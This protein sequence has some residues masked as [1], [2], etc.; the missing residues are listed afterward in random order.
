MIRVAH[1][2]KRA[3]SKETGGYETSSTPIGR[4]HL[5]SQWSNLPTPIL[6]EIFILAFD[7]NVCSFRG[8][9]LLMRKLGLER[10]SLARIAKAGRGGKLARRLFIHQSL[11]RSRSAEDIASNM[12]I[13][14]LV[15]HHISN[16]NIDWLSCE[17][18]SCGHI[19][20]RRW[21]AARRPQLSQA[22]RDGVGLKNSFR[23]AYFHGQVDRIRNLIPYDEGKMIDFLFKLVSS[24]DTTF[25]AGA[26]FVDISIHF[27]DIL[28]RDDDICWKMMQR[29][30]KKPDRALSLTNF[31]KIFIS[32]WKEFLSGYIF[33]HHR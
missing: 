23:A 21:L 26:E 4:S 32:A 9:C 19:P 22:S 2:V 11:L 16:D 18:A 1:A 12:W 6:E 29:T 3:W 15:C 10:E 14:D 5:L 31:R 24:S 30:D 17:L 28:N 33:L 25:L 20:E 13:L 8:I 27:W 7:R